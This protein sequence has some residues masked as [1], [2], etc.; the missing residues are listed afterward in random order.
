MQN[1]LQGKFEKTRCIFGSTSVFLST[2][3]IS[4]YLNYKDHKCIIKEAL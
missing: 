2:A 1:F 4:Q 3:I